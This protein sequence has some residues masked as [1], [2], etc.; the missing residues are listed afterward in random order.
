MK[1]LRFNFVLINRYDNGDDYINFHSDSEK[2]LG[3][4]PDIIGISLG[5]ER[6]FKFKNKN[7][8]PEKISKDF[9]LNLGHGSI[10]AMYH[11]TNKYW[12]HSIPKM[13]SIKKPRISLTFRYLYLNESNKY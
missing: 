12:Q 10:V 7:F 1:F 5:S 3:K 6:R 4:E 8:I 2:G 9:E 13:K 11:P